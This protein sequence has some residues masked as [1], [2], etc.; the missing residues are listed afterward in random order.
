MSL[1]GKKIIMKKQTIEISVI[2]ALGLLVGYL[3]L[4]PVPIDPAA[5]TPPDAPELTGIYEPN[6]AL[7]NIERLESGAGV[8][9]EGVAIDK[10]GRVYG[11]LMDGRFIKFDANGEN[12]EVIATTQGWP[13]GLDFDLEGNLIVCNGRYGLLSIDHDGEITTLTTE[14]G[15]VP[16]KNVDGVDVAPDGTIYFT[17]V[18]SKFFDLDYMDEVLE[19]RPNGRFLAYDPVTEET[20]ILVDDLYFP[21]GVA[22]SP[23]GSFVLVAEMTKYRV[24][25][26][27]LSG[28]D[29][30]KSEILIDNLPG[31]PDGIG[32]GS[33]GIF[34]VTLVTPR[35]PLGDNVL[36][37]RPFLRKIVRRLPKALIPSAKNYGFILGLDSEGDVIYNLQDPKG[38]Y[39]QITNVV[40]YNGM[41]Y[42]GS[43]V[44]DAIGRIP[45]PE[46]F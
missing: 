45:V 23:D 11:G 42:M 37:P 3:L 14:A 9:I 25:R 41:L 43:L 32:T 13:L 31:F 22:V 33:N 1:G 18:S 34:W 7:K 40:E 27:W 38:R 36:F 17:D 44:E 30:G 6:E 12:P 16:F 21:N 29:V 24:I 2:V 8:P 5:W 28:S 10:D 35:D 39:C 46:I 20:R 15:G 4:W 26:Y 19:H